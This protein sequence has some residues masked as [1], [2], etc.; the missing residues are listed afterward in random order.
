LKAGSTAPPGRAL[1]AICAIVMLLGAGLRF[2]G[3]DSKVFSNDEATTSVHVS[4]HTIAQFA[5]DTFDGKTRTAEQLLAYQRPDP[6][7]GPRD[8]ISSLAIEDPQHPPLYYLIEREWELGAGSSIAARRALSAV[9]GIFAIAA[10]VW[11]GIEL[12]SAATGLIMGA[13]V[14]ASPFALAYSQVA[15]EY[16]LWLALTFAASALLIR[17]VRTQRTAWW[18]GY[19]ACVVAGLYADALFA[20]VLIAHALAVP[21]VDPKA[22]R[23]SLL[24]LGVVLFVAVLAYAPWIAALRVGYGHGTI[25]NNS[26]LGA[27]IPL[28]LFALKW[29]FNIGTLFYDADYVAPK[30]VVL[31]LPGFAVLVAGAIACARALEKRTALSVVFFLAIVPLLAL[32]VPDLL[33]HQQRSTASR[34]CVPVWVASYAMLGVGL[35]IA[36]QGRRRMLRAG[37]LAFVLFTAATGFG[38]FAVSSK[39]ASWW[40]DGSAAL[41]VPL[42]AAID[43]A[44]DP[45]VIWHATWGPGTTDPQWDF[46]P[47]MLAD[48]A[49]EQTRFTIFRGDQTVAFPAVAGDTFALEPSGDLLARL[50]RAGDRTA[51][52]ATG[53]VASSNA[54]IKAMQNEARAAHAK[55]DWQ[56]PSGVTLWKISR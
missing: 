36:L 25:T 27:G 29:I 11:L 3:L 15:R 44:H 37:A 28:K 43:R 4:G 35:T 8:V 18:A 21:F 1:V 50:R 7:H 54:D 10:A 42:A 12:W 2:V 23:A 19:A 45:L 46:T 24:R 47:M 41:V 31:A 56:E 20:F 38:S 13:L 52:V 14:A 40:V 51:L 48:G 26:Y 30:T 22:M 16:S 32:I 39:H 5:Q 33:H 34:Y 9:Y 53:T 49:P 55:E 17:A 6:T